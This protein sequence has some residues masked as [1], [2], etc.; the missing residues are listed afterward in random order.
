M[1]MRTDL[2]GRRP[3]AA[4]DERGSLPL[5]LLAVIVFAGL[6][7]VVVAT[8]I[9]GQR[10]ARFDRDFMQVV[11]A[12]DGAV[13]EVLARVN[14][15]ALP[16]ESLQAGEQCD[17]SE[18]DGSDYRW[19]AEADPDGKRI[20]VRATGYLNGVARTVVAELH[21]LPAIPFVAFTENFARMPGANQVD[22]FNS[23]LPQCGGSWACVW[24]LGGGIIASNDEV[25]IGGSSSG[26]DEIHLYDWE[27]NPDFER[28][29]QT[30][31]GGGT[32]LCTNPAPTPKMP[33]LDYKN[34]LLFIEELFNA[35]DPRC[36]YL[37]TWKASAQPGGDPNNATVQL[38]PPPG[39]AEYY[40][41]DNLVFDR[42]VVLA[43]SGGSL[44]VDK[45]RPVTDD[46]IILFVKSSV[47]V[48]HQKKI[49]CTNCAPNQKP[50]LPTHLRIYSISGEVEIRNHAHVAS[51]IYAPKAM[52][53]SKASNANATLYGAMICDSIDNQGAWELY[54]DQ[55]LFD[56]GTGRY[57]IASW[58]E[59]PGLRLPLDG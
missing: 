17:Q 54:Y 31:Q 24:G 1:T 32:S 49:G 36:H 21:E 59:E 5:A 15:G 38:R 33:R 12:A 11:N 34:D 22:S 53:T 18:L 50:P 30:G 37:D 3:T 55:A 48:A 56:D 9:T 13:Q 52:C 2:T 35:P 47:T 29:E 16:V 25:Y 44:L 58:R 57:R 46:P 45:P 42:N 19:C 39:D 41:I 27:N 26:V 4:S 8:T 51:I 40:C 14:S 7:T 10:S 6:M 23:T 20:E 28:C 43:D